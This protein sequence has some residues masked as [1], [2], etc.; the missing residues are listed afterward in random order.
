MTQG[1]PPES[2]P[3][4]ALEVAR[5]LWGRS[6]ASVRRTPGLL[7][8]SL[9]IGSALWVFVS[10]SENPTRIDTFPASI[11]VEAVNVAAGLAVANTLTAVQVRVSASDDRWEQLTSANLRAFVDLNGL[12]ARAQQV[13]VSVSVEGISGVRV[14]GTVPQVVTVNLEDFVST[15][16][17]VVAR[18]VGAVPLGYQVNGTVPDQ[19][20]V[21]VSGPESLVALVREAVAEANVSGLTV[22]LRQTVDLSAR[23]EAGGEIR[24]VRIDPPVLG[25]SVDVVQTTLS[26]TLPVEAPVEGE[27]AP[28]YHVVSVEVQPSTLVVQGTIELLQGL[29]VLSL[30]PTRIHGAVTGT[31][32][33]SVALA[34]PPGVRSAGQTVA[35]VRVT[36]AAIEGSLRLSIAPEAVEV[37]DGL[38]ARFDEEAVFVLLEG[39]MSVLGKLDP[40]QVLV[41]VDA[42]GQGA[43]TVVL[44][45]TVDTPDGLSVVAVQPQTLSVTLEPSR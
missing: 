20:T 5:E 8:I 34:L 24:G 43:G 10:D 45:V 25:V 12:D 30:P 7:L 37:A 4:E 36:V 1:R 22:P 38:R 40:T 3:L 13:R 16:V 23:G 35:T 33:R 19:E 2:R 28:G 14:V 31:T 17:V 41:T 32:T 9:L 42:S 6:W 21:R 27:P 44:D 26:R 29:E 39:A 11:E 18:L 15:E